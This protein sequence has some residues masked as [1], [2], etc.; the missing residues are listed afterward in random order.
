[1]C[2]NPIEWCSEK[3]VM[4]S[5]TFAWKPGLWMLQLQCLPVL[6]C[7]I[8]LSSHFRSSLPALVSPP[9]TVI[10]FPALITFTCSPLHVPS[11][12]YIVPVFPLFVASSSFVSVQAFQWLFPVTEC[13]FGF[14]LLPIPY[15]LCTKC[16]VLSKNFYFNLNSVELCSWVHSF[17]ITS[18]GT[19]VLPTLLDFMSAGGWQQV[20][21]LLG[22]KFL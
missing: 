22:V 5:T 13:F 12:V 3:S 14:W 9:S 18:C 10:V 19:S 6:F 16:T 2:I 8:C 20:S 15:L 4:I 11:D 1:M 21:E 7:S 17:V